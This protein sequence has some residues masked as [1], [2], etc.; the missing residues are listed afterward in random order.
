MKAYVWEGPNRLRLEAD[1][2]DPV[3]GA[4]D[5]VLKVLSAGICSTDAHIVS[6]RLDCGKP[7]AVLGHEICGEVLETGR[8]VVGF[9]AGDRVVVETSIGCGRCRP[10]HTGNKHLCR[11]FRE[12]GFPPVDGGYAQYVAVP[13]GC[14]R[15]IPSAVSNDQGGILEASICPFGAIYRQGM[16]MGSS[17]LVFGGGVAA[18][19]FIQAVRCH[20]PRKVIVAA[21]KDWQ[22][23]CA[24]R[25]GAD[26]TIDTSRED[27]D[28]RVMEETD[29]EG[30]ELSIDATGAPAT[31]ER[32]IGLTAKG[33]RCILYGLP[34]D[35]ADIAFPVKTMIFRQI[36]VSGG[37]NNELA[38]DP[39]IGLIA[40]GR[41]NTADMVTH[42]FAF[43]ELPEAMRLV[44]ARPQGLS[45]A[46]VHPWE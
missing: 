13:A 3:C 30:V 4:G 46:V 12:V 32:M 7:P 37:T 17:V 15:H 28:A 16:Q 9:R 14:L 21:R 18:L 1:Y 10:C 34:P 39:L 25:F 2:P 45:K 24:R 43:D 40:S 8:D 27:L 44:E 41:F 23:E 33:G 11:E 31:I 22:L 38:W 6:G 5:A 26:V 35:G 42:R 19:S 36:T 20:S 29:G